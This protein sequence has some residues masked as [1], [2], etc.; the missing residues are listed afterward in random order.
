[1]VISDLRTYRKHCIFAIA[2]EIYGEISI[3]YVSKI[4][5]PVSNWQLE[6]SS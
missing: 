1:M 6:P 2:F 3:G 5:S 4:Y